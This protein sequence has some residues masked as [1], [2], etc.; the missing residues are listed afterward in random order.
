MHDLSRHNGNPRHRSVALARS[1]G[2]LST[3]EQ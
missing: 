3:A 1:S 2:A